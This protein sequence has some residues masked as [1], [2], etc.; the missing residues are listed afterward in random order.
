MQAQPIGSPLSGKSVESDGRIIEV[1]AFG[2]SARSE[3]F[4]W[5]EERQFQA[6]R[7]QPDRFLLYLVEN[8]AQGTPE[9]FELRVIGGDVLQRLLDAAK[10]QSSYILPLRAGDYDALPLA[11]LGTEA[12][13]R[14]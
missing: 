13:E 2:R 9:Y 12:A 8:V 11:K 14:S 10:P 5:L 4:L 1:K 3:G 7:A 6:A